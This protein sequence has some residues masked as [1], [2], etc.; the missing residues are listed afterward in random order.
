MIA[1][2]V[3]PCTRGRRRVLG[4]PFT[5]RTWRATIYAALSGP[6]GLASF[7]VLWVL[8]VLGVSLVFVLLVGVLILWAALTLAHQLARFEGWRSA[9]YLDRPLRVRQ[10]DA[11]GSVPARVG[12]DS[13][14]AAAGWSCSTACSCCR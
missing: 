2:P 9:V 4:A 1:H 10:P 5:A 6:V 14:A 12:G 8:T 7:V 11:S 13:R 3:A